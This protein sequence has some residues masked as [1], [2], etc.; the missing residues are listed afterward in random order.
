[1]FYVFIIF[2]L[3]L[4]S[5]FIFIPSLAY[6]FVFKCLLLSIQLTLI[7]RHRFFNSFLIH[8]IVLYWFT[9]LFFID[10]QHCSLLIHNIVLYWFTIL[11]FIDSQHCSLLI[12]NIVLYWFTTLFFIDSQ[13]CSL[14][15]HNI[16][17]YWFTTLF[18]IDSQHCSLLIHN[19]FTNKFLHD[20]I[21]KDSIIRIHVSSG[22]DIKSYTSMHGIKYLMKPTCTR[23]YV[24][25]DSFLLC[26]RFCYIVQKCKKFVKERRHTERVKI[27]SSSIVVDIDCDPMLFEFL[28][29]VRVADVQRYRRCR[30]W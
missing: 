5:L 28:I 14:L 18:F 13:H 25:N 24:L 8:N 15:I 10:S 1:M 21:V 6:F 19:I 27:F 11:F 4:L 9:T 17:L 30:N 26:P 23:I 29:W 3:F 20:R 16:V 7:K 12:H 2:D 22:A